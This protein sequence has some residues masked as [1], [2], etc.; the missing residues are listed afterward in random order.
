MA[1]L[2]DAEVAHF[3]EHGYLLVH[4]PVLPDEAFARLGS[5]FEEHLA[6]NPGKR[7]DELGELHCRDPRLLDLLLCD[8]LLDLVEPLT[9]ENI[10][11][12]GAG[13]VSKEPHT[14]RATPWHEDT[15]YFEGNL[16]AYDRLVTVWLALDPATRE[17]GCMR[18]IPGSHVHGFS[19]Y[20]EVDPETNT[21]ASGIRE[22]DD[23]AAVDVELA[24]N[25]CSLHDG[26]IVHGANPN[27]SPR[28]RAGYSIIY[29]PTG[30]AVDK[31]GM[32]RYMGGADWDIWLARGRDLA[33]NRYANDSGSREAPALRPQERPR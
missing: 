31:Q 13:F 17:N 10:G 6:A 14:G 1:A 11:L 16:S 8:E 26:R 20:T 23:S 30:V 12:F 2:S 3:R 28:R 19:E 32:R 15:A 18:F 24:P 4:R 9:G 27:T 5:I 25:E 21:F 7:G 29:F 22:V 33:G